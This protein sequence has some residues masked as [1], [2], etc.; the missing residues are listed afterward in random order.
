MTKDN[1]LLGKLK[2]SAVPPTTH[3]ISKLSSVLM[4]TVSWTTFEGSINKENEITI[5][6][7]KGRLSKEDI[8]HKVNVDQKYRKEGEKKK[9]TI[10]AKNYLE[11]YCFNIKATLAKTTWKEISPN[12]TATAFWKKATKPTNWP[13]RKNTNI[14][15]S[16]WK[17]LVIPSSSKC[18]KILVAL[19]TAC[20][21]VCPMASQVLDLVPA[22]NAP[23]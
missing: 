6:S 9:K 1:N 12:Q 19:S 20:L 3:S 17:V 21:A 5:T 22:L 11:S 13:I 18:F 16:N 10:T 8:K 23:L 2:L 7:D 4:Q 14:F 15:K